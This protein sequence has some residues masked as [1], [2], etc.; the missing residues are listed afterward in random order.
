MLS[1]LLFINCRIAYRVHQWR[2]HNSFNDLTNISDY[3]EEGITSEGEYHVSKEASTQNIEG[4]GCSLHP[5]NK[6]AIDYL[7][8]CLPTYLPIY[9]SN[10][11]NSQDL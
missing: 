1:P 2:K 8:T 11:S 5:G 3:L 4:R 9:P 6:M 10:N 7:P